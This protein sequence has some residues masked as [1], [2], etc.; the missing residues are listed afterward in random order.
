MIFAENFYS[1]ILLNSSC[2][3]VFSIRYVF[4]ITDCCRITFYLTMMFL[5]I[6]ANYLYTH[7]DEQLFAISD[8]ICYFLHQRI[9]MCSQSCHKIFIKLFL[10][11]FVAVW[12]LKYQWTIADSHIFKVNESR[13]KQC[14]VTQHFFTGKNLLKKISRKD[15]YWQ[16]PLKQKIVRKD[17]Y[18]QNQLRKAFW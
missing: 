3:Y 14:E 15:K 18:W 13:Y 16:K 8:K 2:M 12:T 7:M 4:L 10:L 11:T 9:D 1:K 17:K 5:W 6:S